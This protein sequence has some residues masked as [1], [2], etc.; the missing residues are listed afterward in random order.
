[1]IDKEKLG[2]FDAVWVDEANTVHMTK[3][4][5]RDLKIQKQPTPGPWVVRV[6]AKDKSG[7]EIGRGDHRRSRHRA[8][9]D[10]QRHRQWAVG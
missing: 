3:G 6:V 4:I 2:D 8:R 5:E 9:R 10:R 1:L 7:A